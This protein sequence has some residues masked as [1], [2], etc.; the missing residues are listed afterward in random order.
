MAT[1]AFP[2]PKANDRWCTPVHGH[3]IAQGG[4]NKRCCVSS[5]SRPK[6]VRELAD[7]L[8]KLVA[9]GGNNDSVGY[10][11]SS[12]ELPRLVHAR[13]GPTA[14]CERSISPI[15]IRLLTDK[16]HHLVGV[17][18]PISRSRRRRQHR[19]IYL[20]VAMMVGSLSEPIRTSL[21]C[22]PCSRAAPA[23]RGR[24]WS[25]PEC[26]QT[27]SPVANSHCCICLVVCSLRGGGNSLGGCR[28][29]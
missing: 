23:S 24:V 8:N 28:V 13:T 29:A 10:V 15:A 9:L 4:A 16:C 12:G 27:P 25:E 3:R 22:A 20:R 17:S 2:E 5:S 11:G 1:T 14:N 26:R 6:L 19:L 7:F 21:G 18:V